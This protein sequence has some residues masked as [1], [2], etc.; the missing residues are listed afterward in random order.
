MDWPS[1]AIRAELLL[2]REAG[3]LLLQTGRERER[4]RDG[5][6]VQLWRDSISYTERIL[7]LFHMLEM[8]NVA[9]VSINTRAKLCSLQQ[10]NQTSF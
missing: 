4:E 8:E 6:C 1:K 10:K 3:R 2:R 9:H 5:I 7:L